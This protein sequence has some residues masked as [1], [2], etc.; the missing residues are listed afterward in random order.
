MFTC[1]QTGALLKVIVLLEFADVALEFILLRH[2]LLCSDEC[3][4]GWG[5]FY[6]QAGSRRVPYTT[7]GAGMLR[8]LKGLH[9]LYIGEP[10]LAQAG[11]EMAAEEPTGPA[12]GG[13][14]PRDRPVPPTRRIYLSRLGV[15]VA[16]KLSY[17]E[18]TG[19]PLQQTPTICGAAR[20]PFFLLRTGASSSRSG[21]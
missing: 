19:A 3:I 21:P 11:E 15:G 14:A 1:L 7:T 18:G 12:Q 5:V 2:N 16:P 13:L 20:G 6:D 10:P 9:T 17:W 8:E 4:R